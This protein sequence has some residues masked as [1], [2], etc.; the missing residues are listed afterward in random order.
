MYAEGETISSF[1]M[2]ARGRLI[3]HNYPDPPDKD[4]T[5]WGNTGRSFSR[6]VIHLHPTSVRK[7]LFACKDTFGILAATYEAVSGTESR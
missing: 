6:L 3:H 4:N 2:E 5:V 7:H 1:S